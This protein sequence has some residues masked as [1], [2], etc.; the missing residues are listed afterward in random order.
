MLLSEKP[1]TKRLVRLFRN[2]DRSQSVAKERILITYL[3]PAL[4]LQKKKKK[5]QSYK[6]LQREKRQRSRAG[7]CPR[8]PLPLNWVP[9][10]LST[11][12]CSTGPYSIYRS[13]SF[14]LSWN[15][16]KWVG[17]LDNPEVLALDFF[18]F[19]RTLSCLVIHF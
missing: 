2:L 13:P 18:F 5:N 10:S 15:R 17:W 19:F 16:V 4:F 8:P 7:R 11:V 1:P 12:Q 3:S 6:T 9:G 14:R